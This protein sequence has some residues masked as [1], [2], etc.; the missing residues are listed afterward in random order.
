MAIRSFLAFEIPLELRDTVSFIYD[1]LKASNLDVRWVKEENIHVTVVFMGN[2]KEEDIDPVSKVLERTCSKYGPFVI[3][4][5][6]VG[7]FS[8]LRNPRVLWIGIEGDIERMRHFRN[9]L[10]K[11]LRHFGIKEETKKF[12]PHLTV[13]RFKKGFNQSNRLR[14]LIERYRD[15]RSPKATVKELVLFKSELRPEGAIYTKLN[16]WPL[17]GKK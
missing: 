7:V 16:S 3:R 11:E 17:Q 10:Q 8:S 1:G 13:G 14:E 4:V 12:S 6:G 2:V 9:R 15:V 5:K